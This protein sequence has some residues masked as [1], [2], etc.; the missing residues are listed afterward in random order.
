MQMPQVIQTPSPN[1]TPKVIAHNLV[2][3]HRTEGGT[4]E[5]ATSWLCRKDTRAS[6][7]CVSRGDGMKVFQL[8]P[9][10]YEAWGECSFNGQGISIEYPGFTAQGVPD[11]LAKQMGIEAAWLLRAYGLPMRHAE[12]GQGQGLAHHHDLGAA[13][14]GHTDVAPIDGTDWQKIMAATQQAYDAFGDGPLPPFALFGLPNPHTVQLPPPVTPEPS[15]GGAVRAAPDAQS[16]AH[17]TIT[18]YPAG[19]LHD[20]QE[21]LQIVGANPTLEADDRL[22]AATRAAIGTFQRAT[23]LPI[24][25]NVNAPTWA[26]LFAL[27]EAKA[28]KK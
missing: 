15:H 4:A 13:G 12:G 16:I 14:G 28:A 8:V 10:Q 5:G 23:G 17:P 1:Y 11:A 24:T 2:I 9:L 7:H 22:G 18:G 3:F 19:S 27:S 26:K 21:R 20:W 25:N 6:T